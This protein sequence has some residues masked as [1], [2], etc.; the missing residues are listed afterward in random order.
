MQT[1]IYR[2]T[3]HNLRRLANLLR[4]GQ[5]IAVPSETV[6]GLAGDA[7]NP[8][9]CEAIFAAERWQSGLMRRS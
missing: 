6:Y 5:V 9:A 1:R 8:A 3:P 4:A 7:L 2:P